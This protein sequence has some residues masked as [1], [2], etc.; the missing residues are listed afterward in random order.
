MFYRKLI[1]PSLII[2]IVISFLGASFSGT[3]FSIK[4]IGLAYIFIAPLFHFFIYE[5]RNV[6]EYYFYYNFGLSKIVLWASTITLSLSI[7]LIFIVI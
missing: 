6:N 5:V 7:G 2:S 1:I 4:G 3:Y